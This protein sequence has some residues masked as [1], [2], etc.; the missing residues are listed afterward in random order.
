MKNNDWRDSLAALRGSLGADTE[1]ND[2]E[3][4]PKSL[5]LRGDST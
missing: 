3:S 5:R 4:T 1:Q 2:T